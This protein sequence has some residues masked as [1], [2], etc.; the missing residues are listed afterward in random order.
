MMKTENL[1]IML[2][3]ISAITLFFSCDNEESEPVAYGDAI[4]RSF[5]RG[6]SIVFGLCFYTYGYDRMKEVKVYYEGSGSEIILD[7]TSNRYTFAYLPDSLSYNTT[8]PASGNYIFEIVFDDGAQLE[9]TDYLESDMLVPP[10]VATYQY[11]SVNEKLNLD[12]EDVLYADLYRVLLK[13]E[14]NDVVFQSDFKAYSQSNLT[15]T[16]STDGWLNYQQPDGGELF[17]AI[18]IAY[19]Y[20]DTASVYDLQSLSFTEGDYF[21]WTISND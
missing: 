21:Q 8:K 16:P 19:Q 2:F 18:I 20:E 6:D 17:K 14:D 7:S 10:V 9:T 1:F 11:D 13:N 4:V 3:V 12:W 5:Y 15:I